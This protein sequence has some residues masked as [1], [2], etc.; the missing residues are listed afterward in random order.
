MTL[1][2]AGTALRRHVVRTRFVPDSTPG[3]K[4]DHKLAD[5]I[6]EVRLL[7]RT[8]LPIDQIAARLG[9]CGPALRHF[10]KRRGLCDIAARAHFIGLQ[11]TLARE[12]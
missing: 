8:D 1:A 9:V 12:A 4:Q 2:A 6:P 3:P 7:L 5:R 10:I 11:K